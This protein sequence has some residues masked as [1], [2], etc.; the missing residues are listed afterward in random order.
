MTKPPEGKVVLRLTLKSVETLHRNVFVSI[1]GVANIGP[2]RKTL[3]CN[4]STT[5]PDKIVSFQ[6]AKPVPSG[7]RLFP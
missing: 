7:W 2:A 1:S 5:N 6:T 4:V 3:R